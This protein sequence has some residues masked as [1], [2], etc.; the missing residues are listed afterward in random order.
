MAER[1]AGQFREELLRCP[2]DISGTVE[3]PAPDMTTR[4]IGGAGWS[5]STAKGRKST[6]GRPTP[7]EKVVPTA[8]SP[9]T[10][11]ESRFSPRGRRCLTLRRPMRAEEVE[12]FQ[13]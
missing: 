3:V 4:A 5:R 7:R 1:G 9:E 12:Q 10:A 2:L 13:R 6:P 11:A 8:R